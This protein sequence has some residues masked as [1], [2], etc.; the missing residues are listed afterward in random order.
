MNTLYYGDNLDVLKRY[1]KE[2]STDLIYLDPPFKNN[3]DYNVLFEEKNGSK[4]KAQI[5]AFKDTWGWD[6]G[7]VQTYQEVVE[8][9]GKVSEVMQ[10][11]RTFLGP[12]DM[13]A[14]LSMMAPRLVE[15]RRCLESTGSIYLHCDS[16]ANHCLKLLMDAIFGPTNFGNEIVWKR[17]NFHADARR[18]GRVADRILFYWKTDNFFFKRLKAPFSEEYTK[19]KFIYED[20]RGRFR[21]DNLNPPAERGPVYEF[22]GVTKAWRFTKEKMLAA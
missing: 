4:S 7:A 17:F 10:A 8:S 18:F 20:E 3:Q 5:K 15:L 22:H 21:L 6:Q 14:Y 2:E 13:L 19:N 1:I 9:G 16:A 11:F 12:N